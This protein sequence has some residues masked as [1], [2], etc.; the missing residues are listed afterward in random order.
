MVKLK[1]ANSQTGFQP[2]FNIIYDSIFN[3]QLHQL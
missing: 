3:F 1:P 2:T